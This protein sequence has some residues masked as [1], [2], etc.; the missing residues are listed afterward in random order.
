MPNTLQTEKTSRAPA[1]SATRLLLLLPV[2]LIF[3]AGG[4]A[5][6]TDLLTE[7]YDNA[8]TG[9]NLAEPFLNLRNVN[10]TSFGK[11][12]SLP[13]DGQV[14]AQPLYKSQV[15]IPNQGAHNVLYV[16]TE[17]GSV[18]A[19]DADG[20]NPAQG[21]FWKV[22]FIDP[23]NGITPLS[24][25]DVGAQDINPEMV[26]TGTPVIDASSNTIY[27][28]AQTKEQNSGKTSFVFRL[29]ALDLATG[30]EKMNGPVVIQGSVP[31]TGPGSVNG[32]LSFDSLVHNQR[33][34]LVL[35]NGA[36][37][38]AFGSHGDVGN[39][40][41]WVFGYS[42]ANV[43][44]QVGK[45]VTTPN[46]WGG[47]IWLG[48]GGVSSDAAGNLYVGAGNGQYGDDH[49]N[50]GSDNYADSLIRL[51]T[52]NSGL[53]ITDWFTPAYQQSLEYTDDDMGVSD[54]VILPDQGGVYPHLLV[55]AD[56]R[57]ALYIV[58]R[59]IFGG[60]NPA[61]DADIQTVNTQA[62]IHNSISYF[63]NKVYVG[64]DGVGVQAYHLQDGVLSGAPQSITPNTFGQ[65]RSGRSGTS[66]IISSNG[67]SDG[68]L[69]ALDV[70][71]GPDGPAVLYAYDAANLGTM[72]YASNQAPNQRDAAGGAV[73]FT[74]PSVVNGKVYVEGGNSVTVYGL[75]AN[76]IPQTTAPPVF[77]PA[78]G[79]IFNN[80][81]SVA[82]ADATPGATIYY[83]V[84][85]S[86]PTL[87]SP[88][89]SSPIEITGPT[90]VN[91]FATAPGS[92]AS[93][94]VSAFYTVQSDST[95]VVPSFANGFTNTGLALNGVATVAGSKLQLTDGGANEVSSVFYTT[96]VNV[97]RFTTQFLFQLNNPNG[98]GFTF[99]LQNAGL[100]ALGSPGGGLGF[101]PDPN[102]HVSSYEYSISSSVAVKFDLA[103]TSGEGVDSIG[104][105]QNGAAPAM[106]AI[107]LSNSGIDFH[108]GHTFKAQLDYD[109]SNLTVT[110]TDTN[111]AAKTYSRAFPVDIPGVIGSKTAYAGFTASTGTATATQDILQWTFN[112][113]PGFSQGFSSFGLALNGV[114]SVV[115]SRLQLTDGGANEASSAYYGTPLNIQRFAT[116]FLF[117]A[118]NAQADGFTF[119]IQRAGASA[120][121]VN[122]GSLGYAS[123][124][125]SVA[126]KFDLFDNGGEGPSSTGLYINGTD[127]TL[128]SVDIF[129]HGIDLRNGDIFKAQLVY[130]GSNLALT[131]TDTNNPAATF[132]TNF[133]VDI[134]GTIG[135]ATA[136]V[137][138]TGGT[139]G[140]TAI[141]QILQWNFTP[142]AT[143]TPGPDPQSGA[144]FTVNDVPVTGD[145]D[146]DQKGDLAYW[147]PSTGVWY[148]VPSGNPT[149]PIVQQ[150]GLPGDIPVPGDYDQDG[151]TD[152]AVWRPSNGV[153]YIIPSSNPTQPIV[154]QW[155]L[156]GDTPVVGH[157]TGPGAFDFALWRPSNGSWYV[158]NANSL[159]LYPVPSIFQQWGLPGDIPVPGDYDQDGK[160]DFAVWRPSNG[161][162]YIIP[163]SN[164]TQPIVQQWGLPGD[165][166]VVGHFTSAGAFDFT[167]WRPS[168]GSWYVMNANSLN[169]YPVPSTF[170]QWGLPGDLPA[171]GDFDGDK[172]TDFVV[173]RPAN[174][175][176]YII[177]SSSPAA[178]QRTSFL[179]Q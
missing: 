124:G 75:L 91:A 133:A 140:A 55:T 67:N 87:N 29:H 130:D 49:L 74:T 59:D 150:W 73:K 83:T 122:G 81:Q 47:G 171:A 160:T 110:I 127:P 101:G 84:D 20:N 157:F 102:Y 138:F 36:V 114:A 118:S 156:P 136:F 162:W 103:N 155:G 44:Q 106:P 51:S 7:R 38:I 121:G 170:Q 57:G 146:G 13:V 4:V 166:P 63:N 108:S 32:T 54:L 61:T 90:T 26:I 5:R 131:I 56:K 159:N 165:I 161:V 93:N 153:W 137:G 132:S 45:F 107:D 60:F 40:H 14:Y 70:F 113:L 24:P 149:Q 141:Q 169:L 17:H 48:G 134:P 152:F 1:I 52:A 117:Q 72:L 172:R 129:S 42:A 25:N 21:Y 154:Q 96:P 128:P 30:V 92:A 86:I 94:S 116:D 22:S 85:S 142:T 125:N 65:N 28:V 16:A 135:G 53:K 109:G 69:W 174:G 46:G 10:P 126:V 175:F 178:P 119:V 163:S 3:T 177:P 112:P 164:P 176:W 105:Y 18:Y 139:G 179:G 9:Q 98:E 68:I 120:L 11:L 35:V 34:G 145:F 2:I 33:T 144:G 27:V 76:G 99:T 31:G 80:A 66:P 62:S 37:Y 71:S 143:S 19:F 167:V 168:N 77:S 78:P 43:Q 12:F 88:V 89:Y 147:R 82:L 97:Q 58:N 64:G 50:T 15:S 95:P 100:T 123:I 8:R 104:V 148:I 158:L 6:A 111:D 23:A 151:K 79:K 41:G 115:N 173:A 39:F